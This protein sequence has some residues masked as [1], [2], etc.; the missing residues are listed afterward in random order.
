MWPTIPEVFPYIE[1]P[2]AARDRDVLYQTTTR[3]SWVGAPTLQAEDLGSGMQLSLVRA[4]G[5]ELRFAER[6]PVG[7]ALHNTGALTGSMA[8]VGDTAFDDITVHV[9][10]S[11]QFE[12]TYENAS[13]GNAIRVRFTAVAADDGPDFIRCQLVSATVAQ[14]SRTLGAWDLPALRL[15]PPAKGTGERMIALTPYLRGQANA[16]PLQPYPFGEFAA[17]YPFVDA[18]GGSNLA[19]AIRDVNSVVQ[20]ASMQ[21]THVYDRDSRVGMMLV[22]ADKDSH[23]KAFFQD[24][25]GEAHITG[26]RHLPPNGRGR[27]SL[28]SSD[29]AGSYEMR[30]IPMLGDLWDGAQEYRRIVVEELRPAWLPATRIQDDGYEAPYVGWGHTRNRSGMLASSLWLIV[31]SFQDLTQ[32]AGGNRGAKA[33]GA[34]GVTTTGSGDGLSEAGAVAKLQNAA[35]K[36]ITFLG[37]NPDAVL[38]YGASDEAA[39]GNRDSDHWTNYGEAFLSWIA[40][41][42]RY[43]IRYSNV[44]PFSSS[45][46]TKWR[47]NPKSVDAAYGYLDA[48][49]DPADYVAEDA[50]G[51]PCQLNSND[52]VIDPATGGV[53]APSFSENWQVPQYAEANARAHVLDLLKRRFIDGDP[54]NGIAAT[55]NLKGLYLDAFT[56]V[57]AAE[58]YRSSL[59]AEQKGFSAAFVAGFVALVDELIAGCRTAAGFE[60]F[61][62]FSEWP[63]EPGLKLDGLSVSTDPVNNAAVIQA[64]LCVAH[65]NYVWAEY[66]PRTDFYQSFV[67]LASIIPPNSGALPLIGDLWRLRLQVSLSH[68]SSSMIVPAFGL[69]PDL[70]PDNENNP[71]DPSYAQWHSWAKRALTF[72]RTC[73]AAI[74]ATGAIEAFRGRM[75][76]EIAGTAQANLANEA[77]TASLSGLIGA[78]VHGRAWLTER[79]RHRIWVILTTGEA[80]AQAFTLRMDRGRYPDLPAGTLE[81]AELTAANTTGAVVATFTDYLELALTIPADGIRIFQIRRQET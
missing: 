53:V 62:L 65:Y 26:V 36:L 39:F 11:S 4:N 23:F 30:I 71:A 76:R 60:D 49:G 9:N 57:T 43:L 51:N 31:A 80:T 7:M 45:P 72:T 2:E 56:A 69:R 19:R 22:A 29:L 42:T 78:N 48:L 64:P 21:Y 44:T 24:G 79:V 13:T 28:S 10:S 14:A 3:A 50:A 52:G 40:A 73:F 81:V 5:V 37:E 32:A 67:S 17:V 70:V 6:L 25:D 38:V 75:L 59:S 63:S 18:V 41:R 35:Q 68:G 27:T 58:D 12:A 33:G 77:L 16:N 74:R 61:G 47:A 20:P 34:N 54:A 1:V 66:V 55:G 46:A 15:L 8:A